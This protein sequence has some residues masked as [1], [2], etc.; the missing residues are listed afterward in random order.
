[1][2]TRPIF[3]LLTP[4]LTP[5]VTAW[6]FRT[7]FVE[8]F[9]NLPPMTPE[10]QADFNEAVALGVYKGVKWVPRHTPPPEHLMRLL[11]QEVILWPP[12][13]EQR[14]QMMISHLGYNPIHA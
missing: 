9:S 4:V 11:P 8:Y 5:F 3:P 1:M 10:E 2:S 14:Q 6:Y 12:T 7:E 13:A